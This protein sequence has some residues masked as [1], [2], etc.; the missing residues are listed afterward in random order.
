MKDDFR[1]ENERVVD[2]FVDLC[3]RHKIVWLN[4]VQRSRGFDAPDYVRHKYL[5]NQLKTLLNSDLAF[6]KGLMCLSVE[7][8]EVKKKS[9]VVFNV[10]NEGYVKKCMVEFEKVKKE[11]VELEKEYEKKLDSLRKKL[12]KIG[13]RSKW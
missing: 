3:S 7:L 8:G 1:D 5:S 10:K 9:L 12:L 2:F 13:G 4:D 11:L 6:G